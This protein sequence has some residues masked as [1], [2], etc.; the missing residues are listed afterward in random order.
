MAFSFWRRQEAPQPPPRQRS[1]EEM[2]AAARVDGAKRAV[3]EFAARLADELADRIASEAAQP[4]MKRKRKRRMQAAPIPQPKTKTP[5]A[6]P[7]I[8]GGTFSRG[9]MTKESWASAH[10]FT[11]RR[12]L[13]AHMPSA[14]MGDVERAR[15]LLDAAP[16]HHLCTRVREEIF[17][18][19]AKRSNDQ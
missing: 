4:T 17:A 16:Q 5:D 13:A 14:S 1:A 9:P 12:L 8:D 19:A 3:T 15:R 7:P 6:F 10:M 2:R 11:Q 18:R